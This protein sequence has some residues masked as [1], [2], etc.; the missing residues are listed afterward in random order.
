MRAAEHAPSLRRSGAPGNAGAPERSP[1]EP[2]REP[3][4]TVVVG[5]EPVAVAEP[6]PVW[7]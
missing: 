2:E 6:V 4:A 7:V 5:L 1:A 3:A